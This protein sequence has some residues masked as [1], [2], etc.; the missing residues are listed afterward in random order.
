MQRWG[1]LFTTAKRGPVGSIL[2]RTLTGGNV[3]NIRNFQRGVH[4]PQRNVDQGGGSIYHG[5]KLTGGP[6]STAKNRPGVHFQRGK[7]DRRSIY[8][9][10]KW[11]GGPFCKV[12]MDRRSILHRR[13]LTRG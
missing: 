7:M 13:K 1:G 12:K 11:T 5:E 3:C 9:G 8:N 4:L 2:H 10:K 6:F